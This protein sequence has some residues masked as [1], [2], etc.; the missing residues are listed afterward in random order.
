MSLSS[1][2]KRFNHLWCHLSVEIEKSKIFLLLHASCY[3]VQPFRGQI[4]LPLCIQNI[5]ASLQIILIFPY[6]LQN[7]IFKI[8]MKSTNIFTE[9]PL[10]NPKQTG[11][12]GSRIY[13]HKSQCLSAYPTHLHGREIYQLHPIIRQ[14]V[15]L[16]SFLSILSFSTW[17]AIFFSPLWLEI[18][19]E[20]HRYIYRRPPVKPQADRCRY[21]YDQPSLNTKID[22]I[23]SFI[24]DQVKKRNR[25]HLLRHELSHRDYK[26][27]G[28]HFNISGVAK[29]AHEIRSITRR[30]KSR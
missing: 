28:L 14:P 3:L 21:R 16:N 26:P 30:I 20:I 29:Y 22:T 5:F 27:D 13:R 12:K 11:V 24:A 8:C 4:P 23:N 1:P 2:R 6:S 19:N 9:H 15:L 17:S 7:C 10:L 25:W 18:M